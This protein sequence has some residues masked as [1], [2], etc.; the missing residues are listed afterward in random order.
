MNN[1]IPEF[2]NTGEALQFGRAHAGDNH[3]INQLQ[4]EYDSLRA[5]SRSLM[6]EGREG[7]ALHIM[8]GQGQFV[9]EARE[10]AERC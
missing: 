3:I 7:E 6:D 2:K 10:E 4:I 5:L 9:R 8:S 1:L